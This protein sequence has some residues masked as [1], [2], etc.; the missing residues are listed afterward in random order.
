MKISEIENLKILDYLLNQFGLETTI[1][2]NEHGEVCFTVMK[3]ING[4]AYYT[5]EQWKCYKSPLLLIP[6]IHKFLRQKYNS[7]YL[8]QNVLA[9]LCKQKLLNKL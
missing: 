2:I 8:P 6:D 5:Y 1:D 4:Y 3:I 7:E 9:D